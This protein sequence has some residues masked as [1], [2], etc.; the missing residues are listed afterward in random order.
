MTNMSRLTYSAHGAFVGLLTVAFVVG[1]CASKKLLDYPA[2]PPSS[3]PYS[4]VKDGLAVSIQPLTS[5]QESE[6]YF[7]TDLSSRGILAIFVSAENQGS[8]STFILLKERFTLQ[9]AQREE[10]AV[11]DREQ[12]KSGT[13]DNLQAATEVVGFAATVGSALFFGLGGVPF[14][15][16]SHKIQ[17]HEERVKHKF[18]V[19]ELQTK[20]LS[21]GEE[22]HGFVYF[23]RPP[24]YPGSGHWVLHLEARDLNS[25]EVKVFDFVIDG[26]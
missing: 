14:L 4:Q 20:T 22:T 17:S 2:Q 5:P 13:L 26:K 9:T 15:W 21:L 19:E 8:P 3:Y 23:H 6:K 12:V 25:K 18:I 11:S 1:G 24:G 16:G 10:H 7:D